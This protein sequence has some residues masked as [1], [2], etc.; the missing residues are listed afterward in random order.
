MYILVDNYFYFFEY[1]LFQMDSKNKV[2]EE[3]YGFIKK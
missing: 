2:I 3:K 1:I